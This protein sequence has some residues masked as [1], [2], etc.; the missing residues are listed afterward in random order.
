M[1]I[2]DTIYKLSIFVIV[3][4]IAQLNPSKKGFDFRPAVQATTSLIGFALLP[5][6]KLVSV[7][8]DGQKQFD[9]V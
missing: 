5:T 2:Q 6:N 8:S 1:V 7:R 4:I 9:L 3:K